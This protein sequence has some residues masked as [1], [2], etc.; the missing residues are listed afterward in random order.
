MIGVRMGC[1]AIIYRKFF[2]FFGKIFVEFFFRRFTVTSAVYEHV[3]AVGEFYKSSVAL[4]YVYKIY[5][6]ITQ[7]FNDGSRIFRGRR[8]ILPLARIFVYI[9]TDDERSR[10]DSRDTGVKKSVPPDFIK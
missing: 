7:S 9:N 2:A 8:R 6:K 4:P 5:F 1:N 3:F 10:S